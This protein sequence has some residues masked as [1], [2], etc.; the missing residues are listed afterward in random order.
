MR[1]HGEY[2]YRQLQRQTAIIVRFPTDDSTAHKNKQ[3][4]SEM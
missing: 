2:A 3:R 1:Y 4:A